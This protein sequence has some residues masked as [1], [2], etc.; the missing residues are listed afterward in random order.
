[1][2]LQRLA[3]IAEFGW[4]AAAVGAHGV[5]LAFCLI[6][7]AAGAT[8]IGDLAAEVLRLVQLS[9]LPLWLILGPG[10]KRLRWIAIPAFCGLLYAWSDL[11]Y[12]SVGEETY[13]LGLETVAILLALSL[14]VRLG[15]GRVRSMVGRTPLPVQFSIRGLL[16]TTTLAAFLVVGGK[17]IYANVQSVGTNDQPDLLELN[18][19]IARTAVAVGLAMISL[20][21]WWAVFRPRRVWL[22]CL[23]VAIGSGICGMLT[24]LLLHQTDAWLSFGLWWLL[25]A[26]AIM[27][28]LAPLRQMGFRLAVL[29][30]TRGAS[31]SPAKELKMCRAEAPLTGVPS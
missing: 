19:L 5:V 6:D 1:M 31:L 3:T 28:T 22:T 27:A 4:L 18:P 12:P 15:G 20:A 13:W 26:L 21:A 14:A 9:L 25:H 7:H 29:K 2:S 8:A 23:G 24:T 10:P 11:P 17:W 16:I 30:S